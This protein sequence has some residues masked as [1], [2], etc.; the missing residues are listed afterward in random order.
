LPAIE[1]FEIDG[2]K[3]GPVM[4]NVGQHV[5]FP[6]FVIVAVFGVEPPPKLNGKLRG[7]LKPPAGPGRLIVVV[8]VGAEYR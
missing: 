8:R 5:T 1:P 4:T 7:K 3:H 6:A 2:F